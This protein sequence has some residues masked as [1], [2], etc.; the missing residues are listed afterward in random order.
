MRK[1]NC[2]SE[3]GAYEL[4]PRP[5]FI[6]DRLG[7][8]VR[9]DPL[10][11][12]TV[13]FVGLEANGSFL[14]VGTGFVI[15]VRRNGFD[16]N[17]LATADHVVDLVDGNSIW[18]RL[19][20]KNGDAG[21][22]IRIEKSTKIM[23]PRELDLAILPM[24]PLGSSYNVGSI[25]INRT[26]FEAIKKDIW[27]PELGDEVATVGLYTS[28][29]GETKNIPVV[30]IGHIALL[31]DEPVLTQ[32]GYLRAYLIET[33][34]I[35]GLSG[36]PVFINIPRIRV[37][38]PGQIQT[39]KGSGAIFI[40]VMLGYHLVSSKEDQ[41]VVP[42]RQGETANPEYS[43]DER[44]TGFAV[45]APIEAIFDIME[46]DIMK[47]SMD[48]GIER[49]SQK[50]KFREAGAPIPTPSPSSPATDENPNAQEDFNR[51]MKKAATKTVE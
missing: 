42:A 17:F 38:G 12:H 27:N 16:F 13:G 45:V 3:R 29:Y 18:L 47:K 11:R 4:Y 5:A 51:L 44:N 21:V 26:D 25:L 30:R 50:A 10:T 46:S 24:P 7:T 33:R 39:L 22:P 1:T 8:I 23:L 36:S 14:P 37:S 20:T 6:A 40:G 19:N 48:T 2:P 32:R 9:I 43:L 31:P 34:S 41:I 35:A 28:H 49:L 15:V